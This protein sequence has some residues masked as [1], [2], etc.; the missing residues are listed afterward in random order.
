MNRRWS[1]M[2]W[3]TGVLAMA[4]IIFGF[5]AQTAEES[6]AIS[7]RVA[8]I[9]LPFFSGEELI[10]IIRKLGHL[11]EYLIFGVLLYGLM[12]SYERKHA[13]FLAWLA[14]TGY[15][16]TDELHQL[17]S[18]GRSAELRDVLIDSTGVFLGVMAA[19]LAVQLY[20]KRKKDK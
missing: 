11:S 3:W 16:I 1:R 19:M 12:G 17:F 15:A 13:G 4:A 5:S 18:D 8:A 14:G 2:L 6:S 10:F 7:D 9:W 20:R